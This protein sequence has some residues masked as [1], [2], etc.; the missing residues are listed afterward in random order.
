MEHRRKADFWNVCVINAKL[1]HQNE[2]FPIT[3]VSERGSKAQRVSSTQ[4]GREQLAIISFPPL[5]LIPESR[6]CWLEQHQPGPGKPGKD[7]HPC[8]H[9][10]H[11]WAELQ[12]KRVVRAKTFLSL[13]FTKS[14]LQRQSEEWVIKC[15][16]PWRGKLHKST[17]TSAALPLSAVQPQTHKNKQ[18]T[19]MC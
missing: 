14:Q 4:A 11:Y 18:K 17:P 12:I 5:C 16:G 6:R 2:P 10:P 3:N 7:N 8:C 19:E 1:Q 15:L 9:R 13:I